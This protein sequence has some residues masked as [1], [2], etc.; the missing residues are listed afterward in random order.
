[1]NQRS[2]IAQ[3]KAQVKSHAEFTDLDMSIWWK[4][5]FPPLG[6]API[7]AEKDRNKLV[8]LQNIV[9]RTDIDLISHMQRR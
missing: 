9:M 4:A 1:M 6:M 7:D 3:I 5:Y 8:E 2:L